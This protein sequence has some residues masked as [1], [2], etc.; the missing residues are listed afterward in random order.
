MT[1]ST[2][3]PCVHTPT[4]SFVQK[5]VFAIHIAPR[6]GRL[7]LVMRKVYNI[8]LKLAADEWRTIPEVKRDALLKEM[9]EKKLLTHKMQISPA[10]TFGTKVGVILK[11]LHLD[12]KNTE[13]VYDALRDLR[14][15]SVEWNMMHDGGE[16]TFISGMISEANFAP[17]GWINWSYGLN[18]FEMLMQP[19]VYQPID[20]ELQTEFTRYSAQA[21][22]EN[23]IR[24][25]K[26]KSTGWKEEARW[27]ELLSS[28]G[29]ATD[30]A[31][32]GWKNRILKRA[33]DELN[34][35][36]GCPITLLLEERTGLGGRNRE[37]R[38]MIELKST[39]ALFGET[40]I[41]HEKTLVA[42]LR[43]YGFGAQEITRMLA[44]YDPD[45]VVGNLAYV[46]AQLKRGAVKSVKAY[47]TKALL[48]D[49]RN[50]QL[51][52]AA[53]ASLARKTKALAAESKKLDQEFIEFQSTR[54]RERFSAL[55]EVEQAALLHR[56]AGETQLTVEAYELLR[57]KGLAVL[58]ISNFIAKSVEG[59]FFAWLRQ[60]T[61]PL[62]ATPEETDKFVFA[63]LRKHSAGP[64][65]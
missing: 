7:T 58:S 13:L 19:T 33:M 54:L 21:L 44:A 51:K 23:A 6:K 48:V 47:I 16:M 43:D 4:P 24:Y 17:G 28:D 12:R 59:S 53:S 8:L 62:L 36:A 29:R 63:G 37:L 18:L 65:S 20:L 57:E 9:A 46:A 40:P 34:A 41:P 27:R 31:Y 56:F 30:E 49:Y 2:Q 35:A 14:S 38:F 3:A 52:A 45:Y 15:C 61:P 42:Q 1:S 50:P 25:A 26:I 5:A 55:L 32:R 60:Q 11:A 10:F 39:T 64:A 22:Y